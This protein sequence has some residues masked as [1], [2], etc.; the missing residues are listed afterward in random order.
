MHLSPRWNSLSCCFHDWFAGLNLPSTDNLHGILLPCCTMNAS[1]ANTESRQCVQW[2]STKRYQKRIATMLIYFSNYWSTWP[3]LLRSARHWW[4][5]QAEMSLTT[6]TASNSL[7]EYPHNTTPWRTAKVP[8]WNK[9]TCIEKIICTCRLRMSQRREPPLP[10]HRHDGRANSVQRERQKGPYTENRSAHSILPVTKQTAQ[11]VQ[12]TQHEAGMWDLVRIL[13]S[14][15]RIRPK[16][17]QSIDHHWCII[18][19]SEMTQPHNRRI[20]ASPKH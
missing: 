6:C 2:G 17:F 16:Q 14:M 13:Q 9:C 12:F 10:L 20:T 19:S 4:S 7:Y 18:T 1:P 11:G 3:D 5:C 15:K 8:L